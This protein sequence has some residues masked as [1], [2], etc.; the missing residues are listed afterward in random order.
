M[1]LEMKD[2]LL[3]VM[4]FLGFFRLPLSFVL[5]CVSMV[6]PSPN[7]GVSFDNTVPSVELSPASL[8][9]RMSVEDRFSLGCSCML[10]WKP[11][12]LEAIL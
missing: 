7:A 10:G 12:A 8:P 11:E 1:T 3:L 2:E 4:L 9:S 6:F 5:V